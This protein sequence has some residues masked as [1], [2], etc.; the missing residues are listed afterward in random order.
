M[1]H[2]AAH[3]RDG[4]AWVAIKG[5]VKEGVGDGGLFSAFAVAFVESRREF[6]S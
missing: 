6:L 2:V 4:D 1:E 3:H 5:K